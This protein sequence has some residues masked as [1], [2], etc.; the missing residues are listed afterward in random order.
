LSASPSPVT[1]DPRF[2]AG[3]RLY[4]LERFW[5]SHEVLEPVWLGA[6]G[7][8]REVLK[9]LIQ[10]GAGVIHCQKENWPGVV[11]ILERA[12]RLLADFP[13]RHFGMDLRLLQK[14]TRTLIAAAQ[15]LAAGQSAGFDEGLYPRLDLEGVDRRALMDDAR[16]EPVWDHSIRNAFAFPA[17]TQA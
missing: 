17:L 13:D 16:Y 11:A 9:A 15:R 2:L 8:D 10:V 1:S 12:E 4:Y 14:E 3:L 7:L 5:E 6:A